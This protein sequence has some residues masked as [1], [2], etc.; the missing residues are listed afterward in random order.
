MAEQRIKGQETILTIVKDGELQAR[1]DAVTETEITLMLETTEEGYLGETSNRYDTLFKGCK[2]RSSG[3][4]A[5]RQII[6]FANDIVRKAQRRS[7]GA[8]RIDMST[9]FVFPN[10][11]LV[12]VAFSGLE[13]GE[14]PFNVGGRGEYVTWSL[15]GMTGDYDLI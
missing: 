15:E 8:I 5:N 2:I 11:D 9:T 13:F 7:G 10:G 1:I 6:D 3:H 12:T 4:M 14:I